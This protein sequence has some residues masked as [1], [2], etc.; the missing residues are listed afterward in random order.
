ML[1]VLVKTVQKLVVNFFD[2][3]VDPDA[4]VGGNHVHE[5]EP[6][7]GHPFVDDYLHVQVYTVARSNLPFREPIA[8]FHALASFLYQ[9]K[10]LTI[11][12]PSLA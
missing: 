8:H 12:Q 6:H 5:A 4:D 1:I 11:T 9:Y 7:N 2:G 3:R 10:V